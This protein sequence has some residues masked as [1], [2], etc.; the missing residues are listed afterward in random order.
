MTDWRPAPTV[1]K[2]IAGS[3][4]ITDKAL[5]RIEVAAG[6]A[7]DVAISGEAISGDDSIIS[8]VKQKNRI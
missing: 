4:D 7:L 5:L 8:H 6:F 3:I 2:K 1:V